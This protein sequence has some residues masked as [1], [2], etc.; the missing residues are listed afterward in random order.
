MPEETSP[1][2]AQQPAAPQPSTNPTSPA[3]KKGGNKT[4]TI[5]II[6]I[7]VLII[8]GF[9][10]SYVFSNFIAKKVGENAAEKILESA[11]GGKVDVSSSGNGA[12]VTTKDGTVTTGDQ[13]KWPSDMPSSVPKLGSGTITYAA[14]SAGEGYTYWSVIYD[15]GTGAD[16]TKYKTSLTS[17]G[18]TIADEINTSYSISIRATSG[19]LEV[20]VSL[21]P[22]SGAVTMTVT[23]Q[24][25]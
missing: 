23:Q 10:G 3:S 18:W 22:S 6:V 1:Q 20:A 9:G 2:Q 19:K 24:T 7:V 16:I 14:K 15:K 5:I 13:A 8:L 12:S 4:A 25:T 11:T 21:D 17:T